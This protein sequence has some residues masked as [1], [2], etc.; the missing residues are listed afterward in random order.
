MG[1]GVGGYF[2]APLR[3]TLLYM[4]FGT[5]GIA[6]YARLAHRLYSHA[7]MRRPHRKIPALVPTPLRGVRRHRAA[8]VGNVPYA[9]HIPHAATRRPVPG[10]GL[11]GRMGRMVVQ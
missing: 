6:G 7:A 4:T 3:G 11:S 1:A 10:Y 8:N 5:Y 2:A 9:A